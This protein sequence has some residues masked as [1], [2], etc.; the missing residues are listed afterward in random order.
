MFLVLDYDLWCLLHISDYFYHI[1]MFEF[2]WLLLSFMSWI[3]KV[4]FLFFLTLMKH[5]HILS[6]I[7]SWVTF[8][9]RDKLLGNLVC[10]GFRFDLLGFLFHL[11]IV[12][13]PIW[14]M[15][16]CSFCSLS[17]VRLSHLINLEAWNKILKHNESYF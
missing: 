6:L 2:L 11:Q 10:A 8:E 17:F 16:S 7:W 5:S 15:F 9:N 14:F 3:F 13:A 12:L 1:H 4:F